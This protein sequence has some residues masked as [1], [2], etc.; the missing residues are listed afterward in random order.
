M[1][2]RKNLTPYNTMKKETIKLIVAFVAGAGVGVGCT[3]KF[4]HDYFENICDEEIAS[5]K[6]IYRKQNKRHDEDFHALDQRLKETLATNREYK[7]IL[8][9]YGYDVIEVDEYEDPEIDKDI[10][11]EKK[12]IDVV[13]KTIKEAYRYDQVSDSEYLEDVAEVLHPADTDEEEDEIQEM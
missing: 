9:N 13:K 5:M 6:D 10:E 3:F 11:E 12:Q 1:K 4:M 8:K 2:N 7:K